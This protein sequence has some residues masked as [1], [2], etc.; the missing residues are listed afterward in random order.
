MNL[1]DF[2]L[3]GFVLIVL[4]IGLKKGFAKMITKSLCVVIAFLGAIALSAVLTNLLKTTPLF[5]NLRG[6][7]AGWF[8][9]PFMSLQI[10][11][12]EQLVE[13][14]SSEEAGVFAVL[15]GIAGPIFN[16]IEAAGVESLGGYLGDLIANA[17]IG[18]VSWL[19][20]YMVL[21]YLLIGINKLLKLLAKLPI[22]KSLDKIVGAIVS[23]VLGYLLVIGVLY[24]VFGSICA[25]F[26]PNLASEVIFL[27][28][29][30]TL[31]CYVHHSNLLGQ[32]IC[33]LFQVNYSTFQ[34]IVY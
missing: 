14:L 12:K 2:I 6:T 31:F 23:V 21:K 1:L 7:A 19:V 33:D 15:S 8:T 34:P 16:G 5:T 18:F 4:I 27:A 24:P 20:C 25:N 13:L 30:S 32:L 28:D 26:F 9:Q 29:N 10:S 11:S 22:I 3:L 17:I